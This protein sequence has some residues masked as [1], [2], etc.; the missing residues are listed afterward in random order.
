MGQSRE[1]LHKERNTNTVH[2]ISENR[3]T[4]GFKS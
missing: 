4:L 2:Q 3:K 1:T